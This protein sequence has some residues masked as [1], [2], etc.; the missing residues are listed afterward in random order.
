MPIP[1]NFSK[2][3]CHLIVLL[4][5][6]SQV[7]G[8]M[9][10]NHHA[11]SIHGLIS[12]GLMWSLIFVLCS[13]QCLTL[14]QNRDKRMTFEQSTALW[15]SV[16]L[17]VKTSIT[18][19]VIFCGYSGRDVDINSLSIYAQITFVIIALSGSRR[20]GGMIVARTIQTLVEDQISFIRYVSHEL[21]TPLNIINLSLGF[22][23]GETSKLS[24]V[25][26]PERISA[27]SE[28]VMDINDSCNT[29]IGILDELLMLDKM[30]SNKLVI[31]LAE[32]HAINYFETLFRQFIVIAQ[33]SKIDYKFVC[34]EGINKTTDQLRINLDRQ[35]LGQ[36]LRNLLSN[37][38]KFTP[39]FGCVTMELS[40]CSRPSMQ[41]R[42]SE[43]NN[44]LWWRN[45]SVVQP[46]ED[47]NILRIRVIDSG[48]GIS[49]KN[50]G[51]VTVRPVCALQCGCAAR[52]KRLWAGAVDLQRCEYLFSYSISSIPIPPSPT[53]A[54]DRS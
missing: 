26:G 41:S 28:A 14:F 51:G 30:K 46:T 4:S 10:R 54:I 8:Q 35:K 9:A 42:K 29:A 45:L 6:L 2:V 47:E 13:Y 17:L 48:V 7:L 40:I 31:E 3:L 25:L 32:V 1:C 50:L 24:L 33:Q 18:A 19:S 20:H 39:P 38:F 34:T 37:A 43:R 5:I 53:I 52:W 23:D 44:L 16:A 11:H 36:V 12:E 22:V 15:F 49:A 27:I 21:R